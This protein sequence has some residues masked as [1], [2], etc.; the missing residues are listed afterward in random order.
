METVYSYIPFYAIVVSLCAIVPIAIFRNHPNLR[1]LS[2]ILASF[3]K[4]GLIVSMLPTILD[5]KIIKCTVVTV[6]PGLDVSFRVDAMGMFF[7]L[8]ASFLWMITSF[9]SIGM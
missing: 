7:A 4:F 8:T 1:E 2:T 3:T 9:Y 6:G 5:G